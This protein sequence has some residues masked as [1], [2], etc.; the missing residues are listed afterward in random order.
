MHDPSFRMQLAIHYCECKRVNV[1]IDICR[2][3]ER[4]TLIKI[5]FCFFNGTKI[6]NACG[7]LLSR[8]YF[9]IL[10]LL[11]F[12]GCFSTQCPK[13]RRRGID[14]CACV[15]SPWQPPLREWFF[16]QG[17]TQKYGCDGIDIVEKLVRIL[18]HPSFIR[19]SLHIIGFF[20][21]ER[22]GAA[23]KA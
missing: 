1:Q 15:Q 17:V 23:G 22:C 20:D 14:F 10:V 4:I 7:K 11:A 9:R 5:D 21:D 6:K 3:G 8:I 18:V 2:A 19:P 16:R 13:F 12:D